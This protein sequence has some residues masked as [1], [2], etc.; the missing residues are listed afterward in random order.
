MID[1]KTEYKDKLK[2]ICKTYVPDYEVRIFGSSVNGKAKTYS[3][4][5]IVLV[6]QNKI[7]WKIIE[8]IKQAF[9]ESDIPY[10]VDVVDWNEISDDFKKL[11]SA[12]YEVI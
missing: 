1:L 9:S 4:V 11:I 8:E 12:C 5:D 2:E 10:L 3:D 7:D 6:G